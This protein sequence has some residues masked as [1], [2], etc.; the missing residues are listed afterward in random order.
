MYNTSKDPSYKPQKH[1]D[2][3]QIIACFFTDINCLQGF[4]ESNLLIRKHLAL[5]YSEPIFLCT[6]SLEEE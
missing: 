4:L 2:T 3:I 6:Q 5:Y 1:N